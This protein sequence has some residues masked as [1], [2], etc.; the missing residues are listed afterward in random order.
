M[1]RRYAMA[2][3]FQE[4]NAVS[5]LP[6]EHHDFARFEHRGKALL[7]RCFRGVEEMP[8]IWWDAELTGFVRR[9][10]ATP[11]AEVVPLLSAFAIPGGKVRREVFEHYLGELVAAVQRAGPLDGLYLALHGAMGVQGLDDAEGRMLCEVREA[12]GDL[13]LVVSFD[14][15]GF[16]TPARLGAVDG[17]VVYR[18][19][20]HRDHAATGERAAALLMRR[21]AGEIRPVH[22]YRS[23][24][25]IL[26]GYP[27]LDFWPP[28][29]SLFRAL[30]RLERRPEVLA[31]N[32]LTCQPW[33]D[34]PSLGWAVH[35]TTDGHPALA[36]ELV[37]SL[38]DQAWS[39]R[40]R[41]PP[42][43]DTIE[44]AL[45]KAKRSPLLRRLGTLCLSDTS[46][47]VG[48]GGIGENTAVVEGLLTEAPQL[49]A[50]VPLRDA[51]TVEALYGTA[52]GTRVSVDVGGRLA[53]EW[54]APLHVDGVIRSCHDTTVLGGRTVVLDVGRVAIV[55]TADTPIALGPRFFQDVGLRPF[56]QD[57]CVVKSWMA[58]MFYF[59]LQNR[60][61][62]WVRTRG[63]T[64]LE[65]LR[66]LSFDVPMH[67]MDEVE[68]W[69]P[70]DQVR[71]SKAPT[72]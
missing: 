47:A 37:E 31:A 29:S 17:L 49:H 14:L 71:R 68:D 50:A 48:A 45:G 63:V 20:P 59:F 25:M 69:R 41:I 8:G 46:D 26:G 24:P 38:A 34:A 60:R 10:Q 55:L 11:D 61:S 5:P 4:T 70:A 7:D 18:T 15:H 27:N 42:P 3:L 53:P 1:T 33:H 22:A 28:M 9:I 40:H 57:L 39:A 72:A 54:Y 21:S 58:F 32:L 66:T 36:E 67:P 52:P 6:T 65:A 23:L 12:I 2:R 56:R 13:P 43:V 16:L 64:D 30:R 35:V 51:V 62:L 44:V 19:F